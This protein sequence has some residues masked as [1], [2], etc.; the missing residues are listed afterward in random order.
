MSQATADPLLSYAR[1]RDADYPAATQYV[2]VMSALAEPLRHTV[3]TLYTVLHKADDLADD[4][5]LTPAER[6]LALVRYTNEFRLVTREG[7]AP[8]DPHTA[9]L[10]TSCREVLR[11]CAGASTGP[12]EAVFAVLLEMTRWPARPHFRSRLEVEAFNYRK[13]AAIV[14]VFEP[15]LLAEVAPDLRPL[16]RAMFIEHMLAMHVVNVLMDIDE[17]HAAGQ[18]WFARD[19]YDAALQPTTQA[20]ASLLRDGDLRMRRAAPLCD[21]EI[22]GPQSALFF[23]GLRGIYETLGELLS[24]GLARSPSEPAMVAWAPGT[25]RL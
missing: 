8:S 10:F 20:R 21:P 2:D 14:E 7:R 5:H 25:Q 23:R 4:A 18:F 15:H 9:A 11:A 3:L 13:F 19:D 17:D 6:Q 1:T 24:H 12:F 22:V 16:S